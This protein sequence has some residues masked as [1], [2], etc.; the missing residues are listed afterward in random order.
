MALKSIEIP[1][2]V[3]VIGSK[4]FSSCLALESVV[5]PEDLEVIWRDTFEG[6][7]LLTD[8]P[9]LSDMYED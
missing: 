8:L 6:C 2:P 5:L 7:E 1:D 4:A 3:E 9:D